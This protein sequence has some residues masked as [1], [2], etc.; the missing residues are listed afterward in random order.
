MK[1][2]EIE[3]EKDY[4]EELKEALVEM[5]HCVVFAMNDQNGTINRPMADHFG[6]ICTFIVK[7]CEVRHHPTV[8][9]LPPFRNMSRTA[10]SSSLTPPSSMAEAETTRIQYLMC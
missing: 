5:Y 9:T 2:S 10:S 4:A 1:L 6:V 8:V 3:A 7:T